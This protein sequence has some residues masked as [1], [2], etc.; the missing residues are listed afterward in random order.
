MRVAI[1]N[2]E[3]LQPYVSWGIAK[4]DATIDGEILRLR[5][6]AERAVAD[7]VSETVAKVREQAASAKSSKGVLAAYDRAIVKLSALREERVATQL[8]SDAL[9]DLNAERQRFAE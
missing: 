8:L 1:A 4:G 2:A 7:H 6:A 3:R 9:D 5:E